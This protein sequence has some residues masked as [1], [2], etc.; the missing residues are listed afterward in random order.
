MAE[1]EWV[2]WCPWRP[3][4]SD[5]G[6]ITR[7]SFGMHLET[8]IDRVWTTPS[9][10]IDCALGAV[11]HFISWVSHNSGNVTSWLY[12]W[13]LMDSWLMAVHCEGRHAG[14]WS[15][16]EGSMP[17]HDNEGNT[18]DLGWMLYLVYAGLVY[19]VLGVCCTRCMLYSVYAVLGVCCT[20]CMLYSV[21]AVLGVNLRSWHEEIER[22]DLTLCSAMMVELWMRKR[23]MGDEDRNDVEDMSTYEKSGVWLCWLGCKDLVLVIVH[24]RSVHVPWCIR[25][26]KLCHTPNSLKSEVLMMIA[27]ISSH[28]SLSRP[29]LYHHKVVAMHSI[30]PCHNQQLTPKYSM[31]GVQHTLSTAYTVYCIILRSTISHS[32]PVSHPSADHLVLSSLHSHN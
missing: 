26:G 1:I 29:Q 8:I 23:E 30:S 20:R 3:W 6:G 2:W 28:L 18:N 27:P 11:T 14:S 9:R 22:D 15:Y 31:H 4:L 19:A 7:A 16:N 21:Y 17:I 25:D 10:L 5:C 13:A 32:Q 12:L 24:A